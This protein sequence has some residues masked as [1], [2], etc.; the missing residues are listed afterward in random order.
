MHHELLAIER[1]AMKEKIHKLEAML[2]DMNSDFAR[3]ACG[4]SACLF[5]ANNDHC[6]GLDKNVCNFIWKAHN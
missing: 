4:V 1:Q 5:C 3:C 6:S 2:E